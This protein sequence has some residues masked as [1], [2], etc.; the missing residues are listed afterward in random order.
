VLVEPE[1]FGSVQ[2][3]RALAQAMSEAGIRVRVVRRGQAFE[4]SIG[5][6]PPSRSWREVA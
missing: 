3:S 5:Q 2:N 1:D 4:D 6:S